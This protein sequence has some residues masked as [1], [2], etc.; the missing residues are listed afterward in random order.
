MTIRD[1]IAHLSELDQDSLIVSPEKITCSSIHVD[2]VK[3]TPLNTI[4][5]H[6]HQG[7][8]TPEGKFFTKAQLG[9]ANTNGWKRPCKDSKPAYIID[10]IGV[11]DEV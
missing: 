1:L 5:F 4:H 2:G 11:D 6:A 7:Y 9:G 3:F 8:L 10:S